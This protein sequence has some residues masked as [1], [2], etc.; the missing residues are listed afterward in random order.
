MTRIKFILTQ[1]ADR[2]TAV[3]TVCVS[4]KGP[5]LDDA[6]AALAVNALRQALILVYGDLIAQTEAEHKA[7]RSAQ[8]GWFA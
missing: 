8:Q 7:A 6:A 4:F 1:P 2:E 5:P 3:S